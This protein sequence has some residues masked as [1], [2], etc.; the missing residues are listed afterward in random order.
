MNENMNMDYF[1]EQYLNQYCKEW[2]KYIPDYKA[3][4]LKKNNNKEGK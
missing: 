3:Q 2:L 1:K 4:R